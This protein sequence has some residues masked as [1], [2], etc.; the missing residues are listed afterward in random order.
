MATDQKN[1]PAAATPAQSAEAPA[2]RVAA[3]KKPGMVQALLVLNTLL[4]AFGIGLVIAIQPRGV[5][6][7]APAA[8]PPVVV[9]QLT[10]QPAQSAPAE[11]DSPTVSWAEAK[12]LYVSGDYQSALGAMT[13]LLLKSTQEQVE[14]PIIELITLRQVQCLHKLGRFE[15]ARQP[16]LELTHASSGIIRAVA[17]QIQAQVD[18]K[19]GRRGTARCRAYA[20]IAAAGAGQAELEAQNDLLIADALAKDTLAMWNSPH[21]P[22]VIQMQDV[23]PFADLDDEALYQLISGGK[24]RNIMSLTPRVK[25]VAVGGGMR[26]YSASAWQVPVEDLLLRVTAESAMQVQWSNV[27]AEAR[28]RSVSV[29]FDDVAQQRLVEIVCGAAGLVARFTGDAVIISDPTTIESLSDKRDLVHAEAVSVLRRVFLRWPQDARLAEGR[30]TLAMIYEAAGDFPSA[31]A[32]YS[33]TSTRHPTSESSARSLLLSGRL[34]TRL[35]DYAGANRDLYTLLDGHPTWPEI[36]DAY[37]QLGL[38]AVGAGNLDDAIT[39]FRKLHNLNLSEAGTS[40]SA[41]HL[42]RCYFLKGDFAEAGKWIKAFLDTPKGGN[43]ELRDA[44]IMLARCEASAGDHAS[45]VMRLRQ[46]LSADEGGEKSIELSMDLGQYLLEINDCVG[47][48]GSL[49]ALENHKLTDSQLADAIILEAKIHTKMGLGRRAA[50]LVHN[51]IKLIEDMQVRIRLEIE[52]ARIQM[53]NEEFAAA[54]TTLTSVLSRMGG[55]A[56][57]TAVKL[58]LAEVCLNMQDPRP[59]AQLTG[60]V[61]QAGCDPASATRARTLLGWAHVMQKDYVQAAAIYAAANS[62]EGSQE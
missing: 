52:L 48:L 18:I 43:E 4:M 25:R 59:V 10:T 29:Q 16:L 20:S 51:N 6:E 21:E 11:S 23:D 31:L 26:R 49:R 5:P 1:A 33:L 24:G 22:P 45:A 41:F 35:N 7:Q 36:D 57:A 34:R 46:A 50:S 30:L 62:A 17:C 28:R 9:Q 32:E 47:A 2:A 12:N 37:L 60:E 58:D 55:G 56:D 3:P 19:E 39:A 38:V 54:R 15:E 13:A 14:R 27:S 44:L 53:A 42:G 40:L 8:S 61:L